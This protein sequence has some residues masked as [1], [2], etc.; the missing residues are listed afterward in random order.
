MKKKLLWFVCVVLI[1][2]G[3]IGIY[4]SFQPSKQNENVLNKDNLLRIKIEG[5]DETLLDE[6]VDLNKETS[7]LDV[8]KNI[9]NE[10]NIDIQI[11]GNESFQYVTQIGEYKEKMQGGYSGWMYKVN[12]EE[13]TVSADQYHVNNGDYVLWYYTHE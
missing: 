3:G 6:Y 12:N 9:T 1:I 4:Q 8:L 2:I 5:I 13:P 7:V 11:S 10:N